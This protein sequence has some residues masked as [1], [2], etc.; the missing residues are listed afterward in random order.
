MKAGMKET[1]SIEEWL[2]SEL[3]SGSNVGVNPFLYSSS[4]LP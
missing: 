2:C 3:A 1:P 4:E